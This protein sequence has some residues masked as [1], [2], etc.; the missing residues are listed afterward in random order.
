MRIFKPRNT[1]KVTQITEPPA[2]SSQEI[3]MGEAKFTNPN[4]N[5]NG[6]LYG[7][8]QTETGDYM[9][10]AKN[11]GCYLLIGE[12]KAMLIDTAYGDGDLRAFV[13]NLTDKPLIV[14]NTHGH[15]DHSGGN[16][17]WEHVWMGKGGDVAAKS[18]ESIKN[19]PHPD[20][21]ISFLE[22]GQIFDLGGREIECIAIGAHHQSS[23]AFL[24]KKNRTLYTGDE[25]ESG[26]VLLFVSGEDVDEKIL[27]EKHQKNMKK[28]LAREDDF[29]RMIPAH[30]GAPI[31][32]SYIQD[33]IELADLILSGK[34][35]PEPTIA[36]FGMPAF[37]WGGDEKLIRIRHKKASYIMTK[38]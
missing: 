3:P 4:L 11:V 35:E 26:Q 15:L 29:D 12:T 28:L 10:L 1:I 5:E 32:K 38:K 6:A 23:F 30:N 22:D 7:A 2:A 8:W 34:A 21:E 19:L 16:A 17:F 27:V 13:E 24:D 18:V 20:Y 25:I 37:L 14:V 9:M 36:G 33:F 31:S